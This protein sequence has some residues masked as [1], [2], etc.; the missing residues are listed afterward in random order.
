MSVDPQILRNRYLSGQSLFNTIRSHDDPTKAIRSLEDWRRSLSG[1]RKRQVS[2]MLVSGG[3]PVVSNPF[4]SNTTSVGSVTGINQFDKDRAL[5]SAERLLSPDLY[6]EYKGQVDA[7]ERA[8]LLNNNEMQNSWA[9]AHGTGPES[10]EI[11]GVKYD[12]NTAQAQVF[13][14]NFPGQ[15]D[16]RKALEEQFNK[17]FSGSALINRAKNDPELAGKLLKSMT[18]S[19]G[20]E[21]FGRAAE[22][23]NDAVF[24]DGSFGDIQQRIRSVDPNQFQKRYQQSI[25]NEIKAEQDKGFFDSPLGMFTAG[26][27]AM[28]GL[29]ALAPAAGGGAAAGGAAS[30]ASFG[31]GSIGSTLAAQGGVA[32]GAS[33]AAGAAGAAGASA[34]AVPGSSAAFASTPGATTGGGLSTAA[35]S[36]G[37]AAGTS[38][39]AFGMDDLLGNIFGEDSVITDIGSK[40]S[41]LYGAYNQS[42]IGD[43]VSGVTQYLN[44][45]DMEERLNRLSAEEREYSQDLAR[46]REKYLPGVEQKLHRLSE[47]PMSVVDNE[48]Y[49]GQMDELQRRTRRELI[50]QGHNPTESGFGMRT[51]QDALREG[52]QDFINQERNFALNLRNADVSAY[53]PLQT[54]RGTPQ[55]LQQQG[56]ADTRQGTAISGGL[57]G[58]GQFTLGG[59]LSD[60]GDAIGAV[61][62]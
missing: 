22:G 46:F 61:F 53:Q 25:Q 13:G 26:L 43:M 32:G 37:G 27:G 12:P 28:G 16:Q 29:A 38:G 14:Q 47:D 21:G 2:Q 6:N 55:F 34:N 45:G 15:T 31:G 42:G 49:Q 1:E 51:L 19:V 10:I 56:L 33:G 50:A 17:K 20:G 35:A 52:T 54:T 44:A 18:G 41:D 30:G 59:G 40:A 5:K 11:D 4:S 36:G 57:Q 23:W 48:A 58:L 24:T 3:D 39:G 62:S 7:A 9:A 60:I 8:G